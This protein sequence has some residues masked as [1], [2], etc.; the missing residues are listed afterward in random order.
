MK[1]YYHKVQFYETDRM[2]IT[3]HSNY[4]RW[5][6]EARLDYLDQLGYGYAALEELGLSS[7][8][9]EV[10]GKYKTPTTFGDVVRIDVSVEEFSG[11]RIRVKYVMTN[12]ATGA[13]ICVGTTGHCFVNREGRPVAL[14]RVCPGL[15]KKL[16]AIVNK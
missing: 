13:D 5:M 8:V 2:G 6:E 11:V 9:I 3:H 12:E 10:E 1:P 7:P 15:E 16:N 4:I 14:K